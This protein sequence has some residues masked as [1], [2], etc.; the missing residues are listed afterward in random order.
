MA[1]H[2]YLDLLLPSLAD[3]IYSSHCRVSPSFTVE[4]FIQ[5]ERL[6]F[7]HQLPLNFET[8]SI[9]NQALWS[10]GYI[11]AFV[12]THICHQSSRQLQQCAY[13]CTTRWLLSKLLSCL[14]WPRITPTMPPW[15]GH[16]GKK[17]R[18]WSKRQNQKAQMIDIY[19]R[20]VQA[21]SKILT[22]TWQQLFCTIDRKEKS[23]YTKRKEH[24]KRAQQ[25]NSSWKG[26]IAGHDF[27]FSAEVVEERLREALLWS[28]CPIRQT[29]NRLNKLND[30]A[31]GNPFSL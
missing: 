23:S 27:A 28:G 14:S 20:G 4:S 11:S 26:R 17:W 8:S 21:S 19:Q 12:S 29:V 18:S 3:C 13:L 22:E 1:F 5:F 24:K 30:L 16:I 2:L 31:N 6:T 15:T 7:D 25:G 10:P 9:P